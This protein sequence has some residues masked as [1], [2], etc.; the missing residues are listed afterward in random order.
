MN[1]LGD[2]AVQILTNWEK[3]LSK[4]ASA[5]HAS[6]LSGKKQVGKLL[7]MFLRWCFNIALPL[8][9]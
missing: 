3:T 8:G 6:I 5:A 7:L 2:V 4:M 1:S 9:T